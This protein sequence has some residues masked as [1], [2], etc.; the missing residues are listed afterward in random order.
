[1]PYSTMPIVGARFRPP[2]QGLIAA[3]AV[4]TKLT[5]WAEPDN[6][7]DPNAVAVWL[8]SVDIPLR[9]HAALEEGLPSYGSSL[10]TVLSTEKWHLGYIPKELALLLKANGVIENEVPYEVEFSVAT[11]GSPRV[12]FPVAVL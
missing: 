4:G 8:N 10:D 11:T 2:A 5:L 6:A 1:M 3:L 12:R 9:A 7:Y